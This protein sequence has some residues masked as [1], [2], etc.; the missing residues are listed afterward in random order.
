MGHAIFRLEPADADQGYPGKL[1]VEV[2]VELIRP[3]GEEVDLRPQR[4]KISSIVIIYRGETK[5]AG[6]L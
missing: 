5:M 4:V 2:L 6:R 3:G 1:V